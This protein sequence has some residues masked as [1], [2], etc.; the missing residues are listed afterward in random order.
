MF[1]NVPQAK[2]PSMV[3]YW[4]PMLYFALREQNLAQSFKTLY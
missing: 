3:P 2:V 4:M 1:N